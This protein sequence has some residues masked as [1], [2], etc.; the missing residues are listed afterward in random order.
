MINFCYYRFIGQ[1]FINNYNDNV[2]EDIKKI[3]YI[4]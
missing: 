4:F 1:I 3:D 2:D